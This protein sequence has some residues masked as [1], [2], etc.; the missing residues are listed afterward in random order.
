MS[1][2]KGM[3]SLIALGL[4]AGCT[5]GPR[6][7]TGIPEVRDVPVLAGLAPQESLAR[8]RTFL[9]SKQYGLAIELFKGA[10]RD[11]ALEVESLNGLAIAYDAIGRRD[12]AERY[13]QR[14][15]AANPA[16]GRTQRNLAALYAVTGQQQK[17]SALLAVAAE[18]ERHAALAEL[19][20]AA[21]AD[22]VRG[23]TP[24][25]LGK[26]SPLGATFRPL[27]ANAVMPVSSTTASPVGAV[28]VPDDGAVITCTAADGAPL[29]AVGEQQLQIF[30][31]SIGEVFIAAK[32]VDATC[33]AG[34]R[35]TSSDAEPEPAE[36]SNSEFLGALAAYL[37]R[38]NRADAA[39]MDIAALWRSVFWPGEEA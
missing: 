9:A 37:D 11:P 20:L 28:V 24:I 31:V 5:L 35:L 21:P 36:L 38:M 23:R 8:A 12:L 34:D 33:F 6:L 17:R 29:S 19:E 4:L 32:P 25:S 1:L 39:T 14:A 13:F 3:T 27:L 2:P 30:R 15:L 18:P 22:D 16:D 26:R 10:S 7:Q